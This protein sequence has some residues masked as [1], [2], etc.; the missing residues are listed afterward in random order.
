MEARKIA[1]RTLELMGGSDNLEK[2][3]GASH[4]RHGD[5]G[6]LT[7]SFLYSDKANTVRIAWLAPNVYELTFYKLNRIT[8]EYTEL[9]TIENIA[10]E[11]LRLEFNN[12]TGLWL[13]L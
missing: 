6:E 7:F 12:Y 4:I 10:P 2:W 8:Y 13:S 9:D 5:K 11:Q 1:M 3:V